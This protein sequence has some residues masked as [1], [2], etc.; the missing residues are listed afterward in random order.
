MLIQMAG[1]IGY[2]QLLPFIAKQLYIYRSVEYKCPSPLA[3]FFSTPEK[4]STT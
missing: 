2:Q 4:H 3:P 1:K